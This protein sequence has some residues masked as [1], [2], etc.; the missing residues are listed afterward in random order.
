MLAATIVKAVLSYKTS[1]GRQL[2]CARHCLR[3]PH[4]ALAQLYQSPVAAILADESPESGVRS[5][6]SPRS[7]AS[8]RALSASSDAG[9][10]ERAGV[11]FLRRRAAGIVEAHLAGRGARRLQGADAASPCA[12]RV[13]GLARIIQERPSMT[14]GLLEGLQN[15]KAIR[16]MGAER[17]AAQPANRR[18][19]EQSARGR[20]RLSKILPNSRPPMISSPPAF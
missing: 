20:Q 18:C 9:D 3:C 11:V 1:A 8:V 12:E 2:A 7:S 5:C 6:K 15:I 10:V 4:A 16:A 13:S 19:Q 14:V 17:C